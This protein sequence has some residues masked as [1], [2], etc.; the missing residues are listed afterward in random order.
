MTIKELGDRYGFSQKV[1]LVILD[2]D[3]EQLLEMDG[4]TPEQPDYPI[5]KFMATK[6]LHELFNVFI[7]SLERV[8]AHLK[9]GLSSEEL[10]ERLTLWSYL[11]KRAL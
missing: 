8:T 7:D 3:I 9:E 5:K 10:R 6:R 11:G 1:H 2:K 4:I